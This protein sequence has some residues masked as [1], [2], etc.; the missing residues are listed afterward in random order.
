MFGKV[1][2]THPGKLAYT[3]R[4]PIGVVGQIIPWNFPLLMAAWKLGPALA[5]G[6]TIIMKPSEQTPLSVLYLSQLIR[7]VGIPPGV[8]N[9]VSGFGATAGDALASHPNIDKIAFTGST[10]VGRSIMKIASEHMKN[11]TLET[12]GK[13][14][15]IVF[16]DANLEQAVRWS[17][18][19]IMQNQGQTC[20]ATSRL[21]IHEDI[22]DKFVEEYLKT[23]TQISVIG[24]PFDSNTFQGP[25]ISKAQQEKV[26]AYAKIGTEEGATLV[27]GGETPP[28]R[29]EGWFVEPTI[30][31][32]VK[33]NMRVFQEEVFGP[34]VAITKFKTQ[35][36]AVRISNDCAYGLGAAVFTS[37]IPR[38]H[39]IAADL[40]AGMVWINSSND[41]DYRVAFGGVKQSGI[42][43]ELG[44]Y[45]LDAYTQ[46]KAVHVNLTSQ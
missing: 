22:Y 16:S 29:S 17:H 41:I 26:L 3:M 15:L 20:C 40:E 30:F 23:T 34:F 38:A 35:E 44:E 46:V 45:G 18:Q 11:I 19:G 28:N 36:E 43:R 31:S 10:H 4:Q 42:G 8:F 33:P 5:G 6:N 9:L 32:D 12:G 21:L 39:K 1:I 25:Q 27:T 2:P 37:D 13:S 24:N 7:E 14:P